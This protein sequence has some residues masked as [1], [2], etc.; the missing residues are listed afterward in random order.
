MW[1][2]ISLTVNGRSDVLEPGLRSRSPWYETHDLPKLT[3]LINIVWA[4]EADRWRN[5][6]TSVCSV[7]KCFA[8][9]SLR[10][11]VE[12][13]KRKKHDKNSETKA[14][15]LVNCSLSRAQPKRCYGEGSLQLTRLTRKLSFTHARAWSRFVTTAKRVSHKTLWREQ[16]ELPDCWG[17]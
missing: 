11:T 5:Q 6:M 7:C 10:W 4:G 14:F 9:T 17:H 16:T 13:L 3:S 15:A 12:G 2:V 1:I 8:M